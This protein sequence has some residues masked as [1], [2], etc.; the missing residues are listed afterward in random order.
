ME[1]PATTKI[2]LSAMGINLPKDFDLQP[3]IEMT[4]VYGVK[5]IVAVA[6]FFAGKWLAKR[7]CN[8]LK[9]GMIKAAFDRTLVTFL[10]NIIYFGVLGLVCVIALGQVG[11]ETASLAALIAAA[12]LAVGLALQGS[13][14]NFAAGVLLIIFR[15]FRAG[16]YIEAAGV[17]GTVQEI[18]IFTTVLNTPDNKRVILPNS[19]VSSGNIINYSANDTRR[20][21]LVV[22]VSYSDNLAHVKEVLMRILQNDPRVLKTPEPVVAVLAM[23][24]S[25][26]NFAVRPWVN[27]DDYWAAHF[28][29]HE[30]IKTTLD[31]EGIS[32]PFP[33]RDIHLVDAAAINVKTAAKKA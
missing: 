14:S 15:P 22:G 19:A 31:E 28:A 20:L 6:I 9:R 33:Q 4:S 21:D 5:L 24:D 27:K 26:V 13:L 16:D 29:L 10:G 7:L 30:T 25:S 23:A 2:D 17:G 1:T 8:I 18:T 3:L 32:I 11:I 12:G